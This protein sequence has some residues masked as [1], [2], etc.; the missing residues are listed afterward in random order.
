MR[1]D[2]VSVGVVASMVLILALGFTYVHHTS[3]E[4]ARPAV[5]WPG[6]SA[7]PPYNWREY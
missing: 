3:C 7:P 6:S 1:T 5:L 2:I 4:L